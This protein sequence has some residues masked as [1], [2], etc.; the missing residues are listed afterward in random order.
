[1]TFPPEILVDNVSEIE[2]Q[3]KFAFGFD[4][5]K[6]IKVEEVKIEKRSIVLSGMFSQGLTPDGSEDYKFTVSIPGMMNPRSVEQT[7]SI[8]LETVDRNF[9]TI[10][11]LSTKLEVTMVRPG[12]LSEFLVTPESFTNGATTVYQF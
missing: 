3:S 7:S 11:I 2:T 9:N 1:M 6:N 10:D 4:D 12:E 5:L 8:I